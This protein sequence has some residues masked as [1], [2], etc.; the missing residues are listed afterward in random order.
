MNEKIISVASYCVNLE[1]CSL[2]KHTKVLFH[3]LYASFLLSPS[4]TL[5]PPPLFSLSLMHAH[6]HSVNR[7]MYFL[8]DELKFK[9]IQ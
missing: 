9:N 1:K 4:I 8:F 2:W 6:L 5:S 3:T 7:Y